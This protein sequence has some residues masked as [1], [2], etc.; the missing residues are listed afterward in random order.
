MKFRLISD[1]RGVVAE[2]AAVGVFV[3][4]VAT[5]VPLPASADVLCDLCPYGINSPS[6]PNSPADPMN[7]AN[8]DN[9]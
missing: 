9:I 3:G 8:P 2:G 1:I 4:V 6:N 5:A 7:P